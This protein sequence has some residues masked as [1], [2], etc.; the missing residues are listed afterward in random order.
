MFKRIKGLLGKLLM[1]TLCTGLVSTGL[2]WGGLTDVVYASGLEAGVDESIQSTNSPALATVSKGDFQVNQET[3]TIT[4]YNDDKI[5]IKGVNNMLKRKK[6]L[7]IILGGA[8]CASLLQIVIAYAGE[9]D[10][11][12]ATS[13]SVKVLHFGLNKTSLDLQKGTTSKLLEEIGLSSPV[14]ISTTWTSS[15]SEVAIVDSDGNVTAVGEGTAIITC[16]ANN[17]SGERA[18]CTVTVEK[19]SSI[20]EAETIKQGWSKVADKW[21]LIDKTGEPERGWQKD[22]KGWV[23]LSPK[24]GAMQTKWVKDGGKWYFMKDNGYMATGWI[25]DGDNWYY[26]DSSGAMLSNTT[27]EGYTLNESGELV[28]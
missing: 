23:Y 10:S 19:A 22:E 20:P 26:L 13:N 21:Y 2:I 12:K 3:G 4:K 6:K 7:M 14:N 17:G 11:N 5:F 18:S 8:V 27:V 1:L 25:K 16:A 28:K 24:D 15:N 9:T